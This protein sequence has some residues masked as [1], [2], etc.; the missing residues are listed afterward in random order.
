MEE[1]EFID[2]TVEIQEELWRDYDMRSIMLCD[3][4]LR[5]KKLPID[6]LGQFSKW[7]PDDITL[8]TEYFDMKEMLISTA[9]HELHHMYQYR[10]MGRV[11]F[12]LA[13]IP[14]LRRFTLEKSAWTIERKADELQ[15]LEGLNDDSI[16]WF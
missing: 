10:V 2:K 11:A 9:I 8:N 13:S 7:S 3:V 5:W 16:P 6:V 14:I 4:N 12:S 15:G 1:K